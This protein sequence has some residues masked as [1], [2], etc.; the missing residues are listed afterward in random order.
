[1]NSVAPAKAPTARKKLQTSTKQNLPPTN[2]TF[3][4]LP[5]LS[6]NPHEI[7]DE[8]TLVL[9]SAYFNNLL[10]AIGIKPKYEADEVHLFPS[11]LTKSFLAALEAPSGPVSWLQRLPPQH[12]ST[13]IDHFSRA[14]TKIAL[15]S[16]SPRLQ[17]SLRTLRHRL[18]LT[19][20]ST[21]I[22]SVSKSTFQALR[23]FYAATK[24]DK[25]AYVV[26]KDVV[27]PILEKI[28]STPDGARIV[29]FMGLM[30]RKAGLLSD[31]M[32]WNDL[33]LRKCSATEKSCNAMFLLRNAG[34]LFSL[35]KEGIGALWLLT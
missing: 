22:E 9:V 4:P 13:Q 17:L 3:D 35:S 27:S 5:L 29:N 14:I 19:Q 28:V 23:S 34:I 32:K 6:L 20:P 18:A 12:Q 1:M 25:D 7:D 8:E 11:L 21:N 33:G 30:A 15:N 10:R 31:G 24:S 16:P 2:T 26:C